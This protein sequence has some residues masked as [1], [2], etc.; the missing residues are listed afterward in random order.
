MVRYARSLVLL[1]IFPKVFLSEVPL[2]AEES[3]E[4]F[5]DVIGVDD[6][7]KINFENFETDGSQ[8]IGAL[9]ISG[10][11]NCSA[12]L[13][14]P[15]HIATAAHCITNSTKPEDIQFHAHYQEGSSSDTSSVV[16]WEILSGFE[17]IKFKSSDWAVLKLS[18]PLGTL[19]GW[20]E[21]TPTTIQPNTKLRSFGY[22]FDRWEDLSKPVATYHPECTVLE[23]LP[24]LKNNA[25]GF[26]DC[27]I[28]SASSGG[29]LLVL[30]PSSSGKI[31]KK[32]FLAG[33]T[34]R[35]GRGE[36]NEFTQG[37]TFYSSWAKSV[38][39]SS[40]QE[41][42]ARSLL[43]LKEQTS[44]TETLASLEKLMNAIKQSPP[45]LTPTK[46]DRN[47]VNLFHLFLKIERHIAQDLITNQLIGVETSDSFAPFIVEKVKPE[48]K[49]S[50]NNLVVGD[51]IVSATEGQLSVYPAN[52]LVMTLALSI[53]EGEN[54]IIFRVY[55][56][57][58]KEIRFEKILPS[59]V[60]LEQKKLRLENLNTEFEAIIAKII[61]P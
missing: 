60:T 12:V 45:T 19:Y 14:G 20:V 36:Y 43:F 5:G 15:S 7:I 55:N 8:Y 13:V 48:L 23:D 24:G 54:G 44:M 61:N 27:D 33:L 35:A 17:T 50:G 28:N 22:P 59:V 11:F 1:S 56:R 30:D 26:M 47:L 37:S 49:A 39:V 3:R 16:S 38:L 6:R 9:S 31:K 2:L 21:P 34:V 57:I 46:D 52:E 29:P 25:V 4:E 58:S 10:E 53:P 41:T 42:L 40:M 18:K 32:Y 51:H